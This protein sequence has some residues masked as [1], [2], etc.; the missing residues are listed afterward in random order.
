MPV[1]F[2][3]RTIARERVARERERS[4]RDALFKN[5]LTETRARRG[6]TIDFTFYK[7]LI[8][9]LVINVYGRSVLYFHLHYQVI[10]KITCVFSKPY[11]N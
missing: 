3:I 5:T 9:I 2:K 6:F 8:I 11:F 1:N 7:V 10:P 4:R